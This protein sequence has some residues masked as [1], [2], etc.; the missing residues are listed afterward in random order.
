MPASIFPRHLIRKFDFTDNES[1][2]RIAMRSRMEMQGIL[3]PVDRPR[4]WWHIN[5]D[6]KVP[7]N[8]V[9]EHLAW[10]VGC[11]RPGRLL[12]ELGAAGYEYSFSAFWPGNGTGGGPLITLRAAEILVLHQAELGIG[13]YYENAIGPE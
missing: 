1:P 12:S 2:E 7:G 3:Q 13:F 5:T 8:D 4:Y 10:L 9:H 11:M 6:G